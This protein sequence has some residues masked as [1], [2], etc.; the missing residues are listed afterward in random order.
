MVIPGQRGPIQTGWILRRQQLSL[1][2]FVLPA[3]LGLQT[4][5]VLLLLSPLVG[6]DN[7]LVRSTLIGSQLSTAWPMSYKLQLDYGG[8]M[9]LPNTEAERASAPLSTS[10]LRD[11][12]ALVSKGRKPEP[13]TTT[14]RQTKLELFKTHFRGKYRFKVELSPGLFINRI[15]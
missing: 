6:G 15:I 8:L 7:R 12:F 10:F 14:K 13:Q 3:P 11:S 4:G 1:C 2:L 5:V 9:R